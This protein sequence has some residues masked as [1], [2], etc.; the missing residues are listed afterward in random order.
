M[1][2]AKAWLPFGPELMLQRVVRILR[3]VAGP[4]VVVAAPDQDVPPLADDVRVVRDPAEYRGP[5]QGIAGGL[6][7][8]DGRCDLAFVT[9]CDVPLLQPAFVRRLVA[10]L[11]EHDIAV[12][13][14]DGFHHP[15]SAV[16]RPR[17]RLIA[18]RLLI[19]DRLRPVFL[20]EEAPTRIVSRDELADVDP[21]MQTLRNL[22]HPEEYQAAL[23]EVFGN[24]ECGAGGK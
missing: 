17:V 13:L 14:V 21:Q 23:S 4:I 16:Y 6:A 20:F 10:L 12:P 15:L 22:N 19:A 24:D 18:E 1:G 7:A 11:G 5:L 2:T 8:L 9:S 3:E